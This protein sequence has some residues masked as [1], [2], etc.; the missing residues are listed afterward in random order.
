[1]V[2]TIV[3]ILG[4]LLGAVAGPLGASTP[5][6]P[7]PSWREGETKSSIVA[8]VERVTDEAS[9]G[10]VAPAERIAVFDNDGTLWSEQPVYF[11]AIFAFDRVREMAEERP[12]WA[13]TEPF[14]SVIE[15]DMEGVKASGMEGVR[16][17]IEATHA[18]MSA[19]AFEEAV[20]DWLETARHPETGL[21]YTEMV[22]QPMLEL[23][24]HLRA[25]GFK[26]FIVS[27]GG[28]DFI[29]VLSEEA[30]G[31]PPEQVVGTT[32]DATFE[33]REGVPTIVKGG[34]L[35]LLD[36]K[37]G[38]PVGIHRHIGRRPILAAGNSDGD[39]EMLQYTTI[40]RDADDTTA[41]LGLI[42][43]HTDGTREYA[44]D[45]DSSIG[46]LDAALDEATARG[47]V[48]VDME[49]DWGRVYPS[50]EGE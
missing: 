46:R 50:R 41:R 8:F 17:I 28:I 43:H 42:V 6:D 4:T 11:Q 26:T 16:A 45:R 35:V 49:E 48:V 37:A 20:R 2:R 1:M 23:L 40:A 25:N 24:D 32:L 31:I 33:M 18:G 14:A 47:W 38:K 36:D 22:Y 9:G 27:G 44:Y 29:R 10:F 3:I 21:A 5:P 7:L 12:S 39:L 15:G 34:E 30:Y 13:T 19:A